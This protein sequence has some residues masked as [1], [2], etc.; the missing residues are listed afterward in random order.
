MKPEM[1]DHDDWTRDADG[2]L[3][4]VMV[5]RIPGGILYEMYT[6]GDRTFHQYS[7]RPYVLGQPCD[8][9]IENCVFALFYDYCGAKGLDPTDLCRQ[10]YPDR[11]LPSAAEREAC[12]RR[13]MAEGVAFPIAWDDQAFQG[14]LESL[15]EINDHSL[16]SVLIEGTAP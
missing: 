3:M 6:D 15:S 13:A 1:I 7:P 9:T 2:A 10:A 5:F 11:E 12:S 16:N 8:G 4:D 14:L